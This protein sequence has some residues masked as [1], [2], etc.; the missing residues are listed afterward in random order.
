MEYNNSNIAW[1]PAFIEAI[2]LELEEYKD[3]LE[4]HSEL[5]LTSEPL[6]IDCV[7]IKLKKGIHIRAYLEVIT[8]A[9]RKSFREVFGMTE[10]FEELLEETGWIAKLEARG[11]AK[12]MALGEQRKTLDIAR[13]MVS[14]GY[15]AEAV[16]TATKLDSEKVKALYKETH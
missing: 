16:I 10:V 11:E 14:L 8:R 3:F 7:I 5:Q 9:N 4:F 13:N 2:Q 6:K 1:H 15:P 12:G